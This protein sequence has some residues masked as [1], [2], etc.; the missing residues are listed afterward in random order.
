MLLLGCNFHKK[1]ITNPTD[2]DFSKVAIYE[3]WPKQGY[4][5]AG[6][7]SAINDI[8]RDSLTKTY[9]NDSNVVLLKTLIS[10]SQKRRLIQAKCG[11]GPIFAV[12]ENE[13]ETNVVLYRNVIID[14]SH[15]CE[16]WVNDKDSLKMRS[17]ISA[18]RMH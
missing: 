4:T 1:L 17:I 5:T 3:Y 15:G 14:F 6:L 12:L 16:F 7:Y 2:Y 13:S 18:I 8:K 10:N 9:L 11:L